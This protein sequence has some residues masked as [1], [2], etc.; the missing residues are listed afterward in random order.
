MTRWLALVLLVGCG[1]PP[2]AP[3][4]SATTSPEVEAFEAQLAGCRRD[5]Q[6][7]ADDCQ[8]ALLVAAM[9]ENG[10]EGVVCDHLRQTGALPAEPRPIDSLM[11]CWEVVEPWDGMATNP[12]RDLLTSPPPPAMRLCLE[13]ESVLIGNGGHW[14]R[15]TI[16]EAGYV[17]Q[18]ARHL[19]GYAVRDLWLLPLGDELALVRP[20]TLTR[21]RLRR[22]DLL[23]PEL[24]AVATVC[25]AARRCLEAWNAVH[26][27]AP[28]GDDEGPDHSVELNG[29]SARSCH[30]RLLGAPRS[31]PW[32]FGSQW[33]EPPPPTPAA[34]DPTQLPYDAS[35]LGGC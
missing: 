9:C 17:R 5:G 30:C 31:L 20:G 19:A 10:R 8:E 22:I 14:D 23:P 18:D 35:A 25:D 2:R 1:G 21:S 32:A 26:D 11:G 13:P 7:A 28:D 16:G 33:D 12:D 24:P 3:R 29:D 34:C 27:P 6:A 15:R 4:S